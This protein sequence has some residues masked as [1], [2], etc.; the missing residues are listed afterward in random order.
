MKHVSGKLAGFTLLEILIAMTILFA[1]ITSGL[2][3]FQNA[4]DATKKSSDILKL[5]SPVAILQRDIKEQLFANKYT[6]KGRFDDIAYSWEATLSQAVAPAQQIDA[7]SGVL[8]VY[9]PRFSLF[10]VSLTLEYQ[11]NQRN[12]NYQE[13]TW[14]PLAQGTQ[15]LP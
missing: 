2:Y 13:L 9:H 5:L 12:L 6:G 4:L 3:A 7:D 11:G 14:L 15:V 10:N 8:M 1:A